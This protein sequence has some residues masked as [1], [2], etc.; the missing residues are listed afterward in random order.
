MAQL[1]E[2]KRYV[3]SAKMF[4]RYLDRLYLCAIILNKQIM[5]INFDPL[6]QYLSRRFNIS[7]LDVDI[8]G[9]IP[10]LIS[11]NLAPQCGILGDVLDSATVDFFNFKELEGGGYWMTVY[12]WLKK[13]GTTGIQLCSATV[14]KFNNWEIQ[15]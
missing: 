13:D 3:N 14:D 7:D 12:L 4:G 11:P 6:L 9:K 2:A 5:A 10:H 1:V 15:N 8:S